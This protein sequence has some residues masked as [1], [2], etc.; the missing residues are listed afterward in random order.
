MPNKPIELAFKFYCLANRGYIID[1]IPTSNTSKLDPVPSVSDFSPTRNC[2]YHL[3]RQVSTLPSLSKQKGSGHYAW[4]LYVDNDYT[5][6]SLFRKL[7][8]DGIR[9]CGTVRAS[10]RDFPNSLKTLSNQWS[11]IP[12]HHRAGLVL[13]GG[14]VMLWMDN[15]PVTMMSTIHQLRGRSSEV[16]RLRRHP[17]RSNPAAAA[18]IFGSQ[19]RLIQDIPRCIN[20][21]IHHKG[22]VDIADQYRCYYNTQ[23]TSFRTEKP[24]LVRGSTSAE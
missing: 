12:Y 13:E 24:L 22:G 1:F 23:L 3:T 14:G 10:S 5:N 9:A 18:H 19:A 6:A 16:K 4:N 17:T 15:K 21:Y 7:R 11:K 8:V 2:V 20:D